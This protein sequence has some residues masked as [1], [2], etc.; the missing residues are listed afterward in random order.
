MD[1]KRI[2]TT[3]HVKGAKNYLKLQKKYEI[4]RTVIYFGI[5][6]SLFAAGWITTGERTNLLTIVAILG[7]LPASK[8]LVQTIMFCKYKSL[9]EEDAKKIASHSEGL[10]CLYD[11]IFTTREK[12]F[13]VLHMTICG[14]TVAG[15]MPIDGK[16]TDKKGN[17]KLSDTA[18]AEHLITCLKVDNFTNVTVKIFYDVEK[19][20]ERVKQIRDLTDNE[21]LSEGI[22]NTLKSISL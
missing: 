22:I 8:S 18:C 16:N 9:S 1:I 5:S 10:H 2:F 7:C 11:M 20:A 13:P 6:L 14:N 4:I 12:T 15:C 3:S 19:Y 21:K 17:V